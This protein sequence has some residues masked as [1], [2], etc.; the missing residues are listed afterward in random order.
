MNGTATMIDIQSEET[1]RIVEV[2]V[3]RKEK[4]FRQI[5]QLIG[6]LDRCHK[7]NNCEWLTKHGERLNEIMDSAP[8]GSGIDNGTVLLLE[9]S[10]PNKLLFSVD[11]H[12]MND[13]GYYDGWSEH[14]V[15]VRP[16]LQFGIEIKISGRDRNDI[17]DYLHEVY[18]HWLNE[19]V[20]LV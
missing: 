17:K 18:H 12:H 4:V 14:T 16:C 3:V 11:Y 6:C 13:H 5:A 8:S 7:A 9:D 2:P 20:E 1:R 19:N 15:T 10:T